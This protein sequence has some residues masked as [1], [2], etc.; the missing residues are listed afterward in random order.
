MAGVAVV[1]GVESMVDWEV[2]ILGQK[3]EAARDE[4]WYATLFA[5]WVASEGYTILATQKT[6]QILPQGNLSTSLSTHEAG[7]G[8]GLAHEDVEF[9]NRP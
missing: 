9:K 3:P 8:N 5:V 4:S 1:R 7:P 6:G 2:N